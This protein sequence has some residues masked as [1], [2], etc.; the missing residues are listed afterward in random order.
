MEDKTLIWPEVS[1]TV[2]E[3]RE[4]K[5]TIPE[6]FGEYHLKGWVNDNFC[7][8]I[9]YIYR[10]LKFKEPTKAELQLLKELRQTIEQ[11]EA[12]K[13]RKEDAEN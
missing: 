3:F 4:I 2:G 10:D 9:P 5:F 7:I 1:A 6:E 8:D 13:E 11:D 12:L